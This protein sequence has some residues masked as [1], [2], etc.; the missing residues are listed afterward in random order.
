[1]VWRIIMVHLPA[2]VMLR[3]KPIPWSL[4]EQSENKYV[5]TLH[6]N[7][8]T[9]DTPLPQKIRLGTKSNLKGGFYH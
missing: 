7:P 1:M 9:P 8:V 2:F 4:W 6:Q 5:T 3:N